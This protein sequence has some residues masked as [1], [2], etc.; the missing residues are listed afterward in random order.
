MNKDLAWIHSQLQEITR[1]ER[2]CEYCIRFEA[3]KVVLIEE[4]EKRK[5]PNDK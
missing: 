1:E 5:P 3:G 2:Y 4:K